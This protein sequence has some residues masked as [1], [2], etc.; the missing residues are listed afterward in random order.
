MSCP[1][2]ALFLFDLGALMKDI[3]LGETLHSPA[4]PLKQQALLFQEMELLFR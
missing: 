2:N 4:S 3:F 1:V